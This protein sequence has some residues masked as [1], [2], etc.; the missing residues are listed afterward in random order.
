[1]I[2]N[3]FDKICLRFAQCTQLGTETVSDPDPDN[4]QLTTELRKSIIRKFKRQSIKLLTGL[5]PTIAQSVK[6]H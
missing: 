6:E 1:M 2:Y 4:E 5:E 3:F